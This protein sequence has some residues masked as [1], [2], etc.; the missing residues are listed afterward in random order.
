MVE[1]SLYEHL[2]PLC[3]VA[4]QRVVEHF[5]GDSLCTDRWSTSAGSGSVN[6]T[7]FDDICG[8]FEINPTATSSFGR[9]NFA[10]NRQYSCEAVVLISVVHRDSGAL[11]T[12]ML[13]EQTTSSSAFSTLRMENDPCATFYAFV[14]G[15]TTS[16]L[17]RTC[18][19]L[20]TESCVKRTVKLE[21]VLCCDA[22]ITFC[23]GCTEAQK[24]CDLPDTPLQPVL[25]NFSRSGSS[26]ARFNY[27]EVYNT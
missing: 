2:N 22:T 4:K 21:L 25:R 14:T 6:F 10:N 1:E 16:P 13:N 24:G 3:V 27:L 17:C 8:G 9:A 7:M 23:G 5:D 20:C 18:T 11:Q 26:N 19:T 12:V 15:D